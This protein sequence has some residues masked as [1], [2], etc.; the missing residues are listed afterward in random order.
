[1]ATPS[2]TEEVKYPLRAVWVYARGDDDEETERETL[3]DNDGRVLECKD[4]QGEDEFLRTCQSI[5]QSIVSRDPDKQAW[6]LLL[7]FQRSDG[8]VGVY[9]EFWTREHGRAPVKYE[10]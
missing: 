7:V 5:V 1:M 9:K 6:S 4:E 2:G 8:C 3:K 10:E